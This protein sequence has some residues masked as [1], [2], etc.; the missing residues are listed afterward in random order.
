[1]VWGSACQVFDSDAVEDVDIGSHLYS[2][3]SHFRLFGFV[4]RKQAGASGNT[5]LVFAELDP[6][7]PARA[8]V[9][10]VMKV[11]ISSS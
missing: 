8:I 7:Q 3:L 5:C 9:N 1:M 2:Y 6:A 4:A 11:L 10:F